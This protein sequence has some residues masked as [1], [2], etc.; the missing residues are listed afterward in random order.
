MF[1]LL[2]IFNN[3]NYAQGLE[4]GFGVGGTMYWGDLTPSTP[5]EN[6]GNIKG[7]GSIFIR[8]TISNKLCVRGN[9]LIGKLAGD[10]NLSSTQW[11]RERNLDFFTNLIELGLIAEFD[12]LSFS[13]GGQ[14]EFLEIYFFGGVAAIKYNPKTIFQGNTYELQPLGT[15]GQGMVGFVDS[16]KLLSV[17]FPIGLGLKL[18]ITD[19]LTLNPEFGVRLTMTDYLDDVGGRYV[20]DN[21]LRAGNGDLSA[22]LANRTAEFLGLSEPVNL[23]GNRRGGDARDLYYIGMIHLTYRFNDF[24]GIMNRKNKYN[25]ECPTF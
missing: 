10:D 2:M 11:M 16:Y 17:A 14:W 24:F 9:L 8:N 22:D 1:L 3:S 20:D 13:K 7:A 5:S 18:K 25:V 19:R 6:F 15:E 12:F 4:L 23:A 21:L